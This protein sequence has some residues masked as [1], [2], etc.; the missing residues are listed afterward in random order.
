M[1]QI[2]VNIICF[3]NTVYNTYFFSIIKKGYYKSHM[4]TL[5]GL[6][7]SF[8]SLSSP[9]YTYI[10]RLHIKLDWHLFYTTLG[11]ITGT[12]QRY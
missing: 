6:E 4:Y 2:K 8:N 9:Q 3:V 12:Q 7:R 11:R 1:N 5:Q 10:S